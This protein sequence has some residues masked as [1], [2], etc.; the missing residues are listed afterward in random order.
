ME[1]KMAQEHYF[2]SND[3]GKVVAVDF[4]NR[5]TGLTERFETY[6]PGSHIPFKL[7]GVKT[8]MNKE[9]RVC[10]G[11]DI[12]GEPVWLEETELSN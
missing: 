4:V 3:I 1:I 5:D 10:D 9:F 11:T 8:F 6:Y 12:F 7:I 2:I